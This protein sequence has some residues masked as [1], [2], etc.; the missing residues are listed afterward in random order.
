VG[1]ARLE[2]RTVPIQ[3]IANFFHVLES[4]SVESNVNELLAG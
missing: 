2:E 3:R 1:L 4:E